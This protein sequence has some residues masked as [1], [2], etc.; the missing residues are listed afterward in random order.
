MLIAQLPRFGF[1][2]WPCEKVIITVPFDPVAH[3]SGWDNHSDLFVEHI[4]QWRPLRVVQAH[5]KHRNVLSCDV[6]EARSGVDP[7]VVR[8]QIHRTQDDSIGQAV[9][10]YLGNRV[11]QAVLSGGDDSGPVEWRFVREV[12]DG[13]HEKNLPPYN[14][15][16]VH[17]EPSSDI[18]H[19]VEQPG[20]IDF[21]HRLQRWVV[22]G[23]LKVVEQRSLVEASYYEAVD[24]P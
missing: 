17:K 5:R 18:D 14:A 24:E 23:L 9:E 10:A 16:V 2:L 19:V 12:L 6:D 7:V 4:P 1:L 13:L 8:H 15:G 11:T 21:S 3:Q 20:T 22:H